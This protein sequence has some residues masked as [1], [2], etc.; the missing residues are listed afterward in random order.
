MQDSLNLTILDIENIISSILLAEMDY[1]TKLNHINGETLPSGF[2]PEPETLPD[3]NTI[4]DRIAAQTG[5]GNSIGFSG[6]SIRN[7]ASLIHSMNKGQPETLTFFTSGSTG[8]P[9]PATSNFT[10]LV[11]EIH[12][13]TDIFPARKRIISFVPRH[14]IYGFLFSILLP[15]ALN[16]PV[17]YKSPLPTPE[18]IST[19]QSG[20]LVI[21]FPMLWS[22]LEKLNVKFNNDIFGVTSTGPCPAKAIEGLRSM[23]LSRMTEVYGSSE[24]G[25]VGFR[26]DPAVFYTLLPHWVKKDENTLDRKPSG[27]GLSTA[28]A[29]QDALEWQGIDRFMPLR[30]K[31]K[32]VQVAGI[33]VYPSKVKTFFTSLPQVE[34]CSVRLMRPEEGQRLKIYIVPAEGI[35]TN[36]LE[37]QLRKSASELT[38][39]ERPG[40]YTFGSTLPVSDIGKQSDW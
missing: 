40:D 14:H 13:L 2:I 4:M 7:I 24:T 6:K 10:D 33:N 29:L 18:L 11:Q 28:Y 39:H 31:D 15:K 8:N 17:I 22:K 23:E 12:A 3:L 9:V 19:L 37:K 27:N 5:T 30:R 36:G 34:K 32:A 35:G 26:H 38:V 16:I 25:G 20:D 21:A 1:Q